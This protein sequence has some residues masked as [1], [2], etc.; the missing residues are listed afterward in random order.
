VKASDSQEDFTRRMLKPQPQDQ[1][2]N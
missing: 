2:A 1:I